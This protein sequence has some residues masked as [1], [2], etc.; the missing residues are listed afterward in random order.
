MHIPKKTR[1]ASAT[2]LML[3]LAACGGGGGGGGG[4]L[5]FPLPA[6]A[7]APAPAPPAPAP[8]PAPAAQ[9]DSGV[10][11]TCASLTSGTYR[12]LTSS[13]KT[14]STGLLQVKAGLLGADGTTRSAQITDAS[15]ATTTLAPVNGS[16]CE[17]TLNGSKLVIGP[18]GL[19]LATDPVTYAGTPGF[20]VTLFFPEQT[21]DGAV[22]ASDLNG[23]FNRLGWERDTDADYFSLAYGAIS[24]NSGVVTDGLACPITSS[25]AG[26]CTSL[27]VPNDIPA[28]T[29]FVADS[30]AG[31]FS[32]TG[33]LANDHAYAFKF[34]DVVTLV[35]YNKDDGSV[36]F[37]T[38][39]RSSGL[40]TVG[41][42]SHYWQFSA[43]TLGE[44]ETDITSDYNTIVSVDI[45][46]STVT[47]YAGTNSSVVQT[48]RYNAP[49]P[50]YRKRDG[51]TDI[52]PVI[53]LPLG[54]GLTV[55]SRLGATN[56]NGFLNLSL[57][58]PAPATN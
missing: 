38:N 56:A 33:G 28:S 15:G 8:A 44:S 18:N 51:A 1:L 11:A 57:N 30:A 3:T 55:V 32:G 53:Q 17:F 2:A 47:R 4:G 13:D 16:A 24:F 35:A 22:K 58:K 6:A 14:D 43:D 41:Q 36:Q 45:G 46:T 37:F 50:G 5:S 31:G 25:I 34:G 49:L 19:G 54:G 52:S 40:P 26:G 21:G 29:G 9:D 20:A 7:P 27:V 12:Y 42:V 39:Q 48:V 23:V 10:A